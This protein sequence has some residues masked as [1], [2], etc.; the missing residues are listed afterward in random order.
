MLKT[1]VRT[2]ACLAVSAAA[3]IAITK[4]DATAGASEVASAAREEQA[5]RSAPQSTATPKKPKQPPPK[6]TVASLALPAS[7]APAR[8]DGAPPTDRADSTL[9]VPDWKGK[10][11]SVARREARKLGFNVTAVDEERRGGAGRRRV[12]L[13]RAPAAHRGGHAVEPGADVELRVREIV[14]TAVRVLGRRPWT[15]RSASTWWRVR[16]CSSRSR[17]SRSCRWNTSPRRTRSAGGASRPIW[18]SRPSAR[19][20]CGRAGAG[21][22]RGCSRGSTAPR[23]IARCSPG[24]ARSP[25]ALRRRHVGRPAAVRARRL[26]LPPAGARRAGAVAAARDPPFVRDDGLA[27]VV[28]AAPARDPAADAGAERAARAAGRA[29]G[30]ARDGAGR[31]EAGDRVRAL[32]RARAARTAALPGR[33]A[34]VSPSAPPARRRGRELRVARSR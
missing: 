7:T 27:G 10:R 23:S 2:T 13:P 26:R 30:R 22:R 14:D 8:P 3:L 4:M 6:L 11:L 21:R 9:T 16:C 34:A 12:G 33:D 25:R 19:C 20:W 28:P 5:P 29:A 24:I 1:I 18:R 15:T 17:R 32:E 31:A